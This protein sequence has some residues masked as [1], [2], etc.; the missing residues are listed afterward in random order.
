VLGKIFGP[1]I[2]R[3]NKGEVSGKIMT[4]H[5]KDIRGLCRPI[6]LGRWWACD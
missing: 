4:L 2:C 1:K 3:P 5:N 6:N